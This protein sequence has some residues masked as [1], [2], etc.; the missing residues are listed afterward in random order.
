LCRNSRA[1][2]NSFI[3]LATIFGGVYVEADREPNMV[4][5]SLFAN[6]RSTDCPTSLPLR[7]AGVTIDI[8]E[9]CVVAHNLFVDIH[10]GFAVQ[11]HL[12][13]ADRIAA[14]R[15]GLCR[16]HQ[17]LN[18]VFVRCPKRVLLARAEDNFCD[19]N[20]YDA[21][22]ARASFCIEHPAPPARLDFPAWREY[23]GYDAGGSEQKLDA[24]VDV[25]AGRVTLTMRRSPAVPVP[26]LGDRAAPC[27]GPWSDPSGDARPIPGHGPT[28]RQS[29]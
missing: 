8:S 20:V 21:R 3:N 15:S 11:G 22:D 26:G 4:D 23:Y 29:S 5:H 7:G 1:T 19:G 17:V 13:Q 6:I 12:S 18:N 25:D 14:S 9:K 2:G 16:K 27:A 10:E 28:A 24:V